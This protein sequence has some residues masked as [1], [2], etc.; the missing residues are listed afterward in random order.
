[1]AAAGAALA[2]RGA[3]HA[4]DALTSIFTSATTHA[5]A[6]ALISAAAI[7]GIGVAFGTYSASHPIRRPT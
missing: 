4:R 5:A 7:A 1:M 6:T 3:A 2:W